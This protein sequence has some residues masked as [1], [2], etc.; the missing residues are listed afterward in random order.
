MDYQLSGNVS[1]DTALS[2]GK[3]LGVQALITG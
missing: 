3:Q 1:D 2:I